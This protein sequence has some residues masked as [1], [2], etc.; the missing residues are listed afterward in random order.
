MIRSALDH[1]AAADIEAGR[2]AALLSMG[3]LT[4]AVR[5]TREA[6]ELAERQGAIVTLAMGHQQL[7][8]LWA[9]QGDAE[10]FE[11]TFARALAILDHAGLPERHAEARERHFGI[12]KART[13]QKRGS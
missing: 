3:D 5:W 13:E 9:E 4:E 11:A 10:R 12:R 6:I 2:A 7:G 8:E 1:F